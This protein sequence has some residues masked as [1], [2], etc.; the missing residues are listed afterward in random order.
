MLAVRKRQMNKVRIIVALLGIFL[1]YLVRIPRG[2]AWVEQY[3]DTS[4]LGFV[5]FGAFNAI[6]WGSLIAFSF[7]FRRP[8]P[9]L[10]PCTTGFAF[11][12]W[13]HY[14]LDLGA[15]A[16]AALAVIFIPIFAL[17]PIA[18][19]SAVGYVVD[20]WLASRDHTA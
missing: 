2:M 14:G 3:T 16:Q 12:G 17:V 15:D 20:R 5:F 18:L 11:L 13:A 1:P 8:A 9:F 7:L 4:I 10:I 19:G 6:A